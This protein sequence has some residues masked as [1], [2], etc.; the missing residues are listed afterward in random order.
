MPV[1]P[2]T[3]ACQKDRPFGAFAEGQV[4][5]PGCARGERDGDF[6]AALPRDH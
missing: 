4:D 6:F 1:Q 5:R 3:I 2:T